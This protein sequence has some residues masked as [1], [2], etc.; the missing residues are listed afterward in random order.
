MADTITLRQ[1]GP[2]DV[3][4]LMAVEPGLFDYAVRPEQARA[5]LDE[6]LHEIILAFDGDQ[7]VGMASGQVLLHPD[8]APAFFVNEVGVRDTYQRRGI[9]KRLCAALMQVARARGC[10]GI[11]LATEGDNAAARALYRS[12]DARETGEIVV[13]DWDGAMDA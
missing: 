6:P 11:W 4:L 10:E 9:A 12:L 13:Y 8:K 7:A 5:F 2:D 1:L 3:D